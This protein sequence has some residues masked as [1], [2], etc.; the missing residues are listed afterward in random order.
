M[1]SNIVIAIL[2]SSTILSCKT[3]ISQLADS[4]PSSAGKYLSL[5]IEMLEKLEKEESVKSIKDQF[6]SSSLED[7]AQ[8]INTDEERYAF[9]V[10]I[11][12]AYIIS[13]LKDNPEYYEDRRSFYKQPY[14]KIAGR[15]FTFAE[16]EHGV[17]RR[18]QKE[19]FLGYISHFFP[20]KYQRVLRPEERDYR[21][22]FAL[23]CGAKS[24]PP[25][26]ILRLNN[27]DQQMDK[28]TTDYLK[29]MTEYTPS[30]NKVVTTPLFSW[31]RGDFGGKKGIKRILLEQGLIP[32]KK[33]QLEFGPYDWTL[34]ID[35]FA[36]D[37]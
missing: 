33:V 27:L 19:Y 25:V 6:A 37:N 26:P 28:L 4:S 18:S 21:V 10:N 9:W 7:I 16:I 32:N 34:E 31:F 24:C 20:P 3:H 11:Y 13:V 14:I 5:S 29:A 30:I 15:D 2:L 36:A 12:N 23:N 35:N 22:H 8:E 1:N 17:L